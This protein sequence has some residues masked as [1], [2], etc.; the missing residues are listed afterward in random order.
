MWERTAREAP[1]NEERHH[2][3]A[4]R[5]STS[6]I[7]DGEHLYAY[8]GSQ[9][10]FCYDMEGNL[11]WEKDLGNMRTA[12][13]FGEGGAPA[14]HGSTLLVNWDHEGDSFI[15]ALDKQSGDELWRK[16]R[17]ERTS[18]STPLVVE[19]NGRRQVIVSAS[20][21]TRSYDLE[22]GDVIWECAGLG[23]NVIPTPLHEDGVVYVTS[24]H[25][26]P[27]MQAILLDRAKGD[28]AGTDAVLWSIDRD[29][30]YVSSPVLTNGRLYFVK[31]RNATL[32]CYDAKTGEALFGPLRLEGLGTVYASLVGVSDRIYLSDL[33]GNTL[34]IRNS[35]E[36]EVLATNK[37]DDGLAASPVIVGDELYL[38]GHSHLYRIQAE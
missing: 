38:R 30:P 10:L 1:P 18:W 22:T 9:G 2:P 3:T 20:A 27:A 21:K 33:D 35:P 37:L 14:I 32:S 4:T 11:K 25:R 24:G 31:N 36:F 28:I 15:V 17:Q 26:R 12:R 7:T 34:V 6:G 13:S 5:A 23:S 19:H 8:F 16:E 29:T